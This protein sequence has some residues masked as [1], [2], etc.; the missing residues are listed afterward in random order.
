MK[1]VSFEM[2]VSE[3]FDLS[4]GRTVF[5]GSIDSESPFLGPGP[6]ELWIEGELVSTFEIEGEMLPDRWTSAGQ[7]AV[8][9][10]EAVEVDRNRIRSSHAV[11][12]SRELPALS[13]SGTARE[14]TS[15]GRTG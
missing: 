4:D 3:V 15:F 6:C 9:T 7:R 12:K 1:S 14:S 2:H 8:S 11:L 10:L 13:A 5:V